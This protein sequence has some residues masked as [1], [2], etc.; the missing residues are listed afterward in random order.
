MA[1]GI[2]VRWGQLHL[3]HVW[4]GS[5]V[6]GTS[7]L[8]LLVTAKLGIT[9]SLS[10]LSLHLLTAPLVTFVLKDTTA[11]LEV[12]RPLLAILGLIY[13]TQ[14]LRQALSVWPVLQATIAML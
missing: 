3:C 9:A 11:C 1:L 13:H 5:T 7:W 6:R 12:L 4:V 14:V 2:I 8:L 10:L